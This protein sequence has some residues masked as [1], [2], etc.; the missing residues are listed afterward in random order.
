MRTDWP[1]IVRVALLPEVIWER[2]SP[3][4]WLRGDGRTLL[5]VPLYSQVQEE[6]IL[7]TA[8]A[9]VYAIDA[10]GFSKGNVYELPA[11]T[12]MSEQEIASQLGGDGSSRLVGFIVEGSSVDQIHFETLDSGVCE[13]DLIVWCN[14]RGRKVYYQI[15]NAQTHEETLEN[16]RRGF[17]VGAA[18]QLGTL[19]SGRGF[20]KYPWVPP[21]N[22][23]V[24]LVPSDFGGDAD[25]CAPTDFVYG[26]VPGT[27]LKVGGPLLEN[28][29]FHTAILGI[30]GSGKTQ[31]AFE[32]I[33]FVK[34]SKRKVI[35]IDLTSRYQDQLSSL[36]PR[37]LS[38]GAE[39]AT[40]LGQKLFD[41]ETGAYGAGA[42]KKI[43]KT[44][45]D[46]LRKDIGSRIAAFLTD[47]D[48][49]SY[50]GI[51]RLNEISNT[52][53]TLYITE[54]YMTCLLN[55]TRDHRGKC[56]E[57]LVVVEEAHTVMPE[58]NTMGLA[59][60]DSRGLVSKIAQIALQGRKFGVGLLVIA[61]R[62]ATVSKT[63]LTQCNTV[64]SL[65][66]FDDTRP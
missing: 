20:V 54:L 56:P 15:S 8:H 13:Q 66:C 47:D 2:S 49:D 3:K 38:L 65:T 34:A 6:S 37:D 22:T 28:L 25:I 23:P 62:T 18:A 17:Q 39:L 30:T 52:K 32:M 21:M 19:S 40:D 11:G 29:S 26:T 33:R 7:G 55:Y 10:T 46:S 58:P 41:A 14:A 1:D 60:Q 27:K 16:D 35:C 31:L 59:D 50:V 57:V 42:E 61:Q 45:S 43:L 53:A 51:I 44:F 4:I 5:L 24:F 63:V 9:S 36:K 64:V 48:G 12:A